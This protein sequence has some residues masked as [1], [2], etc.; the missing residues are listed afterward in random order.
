MDGAWKVHTKFPKSTDVHARVSATAPILNE[1]I[2]T[3]ESGDIHD[4]VQCFQDLMLEKI[5]ADLLDDDVWANVE[6]V[7]VHPDNREGA[8]I[9]PIDAHNLLHRIFKDGFSM[10][11]TELLACEIPA[12]KVG[13]GWRQFNE[14][15][16]N[17]AAG[18]LPTIQK[19][20]LTLVTVRG[21]HTTT[22]VRL[23]KLGARTV[24][25]ELAIDGQISMSKVCELRPSFKEA[26]SKGLPY[27]VIKAEL[28]EACPKLMSTLSR[29]GNLAHGVHR[30][31]TA[32]QRCMSVLH[33]HK[34]AEGGDWELAKKIAC[35]GQPPDFETNVEHF[36]AF[37]QAHA[38]GVDGHYLH[39]LELYERSLGVKRSI[40]PSDL[41]RLASIKLLDA[42]RY[43]PAMVKTLLNAP[44]SKVTNGYADVF[45]AT[46]ISGLMPHGKCAKLVAQASELMTSATTFLTAYS[47]MTPDAFA[48]YIDEMEV[49][50]VMHVHQI[51]VETRKWY[52][53][54]LHIAAAMYDDVKQA[55][56]LLPVWNRILSVKD[57]RPNQGSQSM[58]IR[59]LREDGKIPNSELL[60][61]GFTMGATIIKQKD[62]ESLYKI[63]TIDE[64]KVRLIPIEGEGDA[65][66]LSTLE[67]IKDWRVRT[68]P[69]EEIYLPKDRKSL[70][71]SWDLLTSIWKGHMKAAMLSEFIASSENH[72]KIIRKLEQ[73]VVALID[74]A[75]GDLT[76]V[77]LT[78]N[79]Y[80]QVLKYAL[81]DS[82][83]TINCGTAF[84]VDSKPVAILVKPNLI[85]PKEVKQRDASTFDKKHEDFIASY[86]AVRQLFDT[87]LVNL[88]KEMQSACIKIGSES[89]TVNVPIFKNVVNIKA[90]EEIVARKA[91]VDSDAEAA[92]KRAN[93]N[94]VGETD[95]DAKR[96]CTDK[97]KGTGK[98]R[99][100]GSG[101]K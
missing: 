51:K 83:A 54:L 18:L 34:L 36:K 66:G 21:S 92:K 20:D 99:G 85:F 52:K 77:A 73:K 13:D 27:T 91:V 93:T 11:L 74:F 76:I 67:L 15:L 61:M 49:R 44:A 8:G 90:G 42:P 12:N 2:H 41:T 70:T 80:L 65:L 1:M 86:W 87:R 29:T 22:A 100:R 26:C 10:R 60:T 43:V 23:V 101:R 35:R 58:K 48:K 64:L 25:N 3:F 59:E 16:A 45:S 84:N 69:V 82:S 38:G 96:N 50:M 6:K 88:Q 9:V 53:S 47:Q 89:V 98:G 95:P 5:R 24:H 39:A 94:S 46:D 37:V 56:P 75:P 14:D 32:L 33:A 57:P 68:A 30:E 4:G 62:G 7:G 79:V 71:S 17:G 72:M 97:S 19:S 78:N 55:D 81:D 28:V 31:A 63:E 40:K